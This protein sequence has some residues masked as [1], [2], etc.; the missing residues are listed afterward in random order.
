MTM[1]DNTKPL[2]PKSAF[3]KASFAERETGYL[4][5]MQSDVFVSSPAYNKLETIFGLYMLRFRELNRLT[6]V[7]WSAGED[8]QDLVDAATVESDRLEKAQIALLNSPENHVA[9]LLEQAKADSDKLGDVQRANLRECETIY[10]FY[11][12]MADPETSALY[13]GLLEM[14]KNSTQQAAQAW[15]IS[16]EKGQ[17]AAFEY[18]KPF[19]EQAFK[20]RRALAEAAA[21]KYGGTPMDMVLGEWCP[22]RN[23]ADVE[24]IMERLKAELPETIRD[25]KA[26]QGRMEPPVALP[27]ISEEKQMALLIDLKDTLL[28]AA[29]WDDTAIEKAGISIELLPTGNF[30]V[31]SDKDL[32]VA[33][34]VEEDNPMMGLI[35][36]AHEYGHMIAQLESNRWPQALTEQ[37]V[38]TI[39]A[40]DIHETAALL[41]ENAL[42]QPEFFE[43]LQPLME[44]HWGVPKES[45]ANGALSAKNMYKQSIWP[46][47]EKNIWWTTSIVRPIR[48]VIWTEAEK[49]LLDGAMTLDEVPAHSDAVWKEFMGADFE[50]Q[51]FFDAEGYWLDKMQGYYWSYMAAELRVKPVAAQAKQDLLIHPAQDMQAYLKVYAHQGRNKISG[52][53][54]LYMP[55]EM[56]A[57]IIGPGED[58][59]ALYIEALKDELRP[60]MMAATCPSPVAGQHPHSF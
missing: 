25:I 27:P 36:A 59:I 33:L 21:K 40:E 56:E 13:S 47:V 9:D 26:M 11:S 31:G 29:G 18:E 38:S 28:K 22:Y 39:L 20:A 10:R 53:G 51:P 49:G 45:M 44:K 12:P 16:L 32:K 58:S 60:L 5:R 48:A 14:I 43:K 24:K 2:S 46:D 34:Q 6:A 1:V 3:N 37:P 55:H 54:S 35:S 52:P 7:R 19:M 42:K 57:R 41:M 8:A 30:C 17:A 15:E 50:P 4:A 23:Y